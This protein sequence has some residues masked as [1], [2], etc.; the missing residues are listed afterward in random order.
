MS[1][2]TNRPF[3]IEILLEIKTYDVDF[4]GVVSNIVYV[5]WL[6]DL[7]NALLNRHFSLQRLLDSGVLPAVAQTRI[8]YK[9]PLRLA[10]RPKGRMWA[11]DVGEKYFLLE[12][13]FVLDSQVV[14]TA[15]QVAVFVGKDDWQPTNMPEELA[16]LYTQMSPQAKD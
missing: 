10:D 15:E 1:S 2:E 4:A 3:E 13:E 14:A 8:D 16:R 9:A 12:A 11:K 5:R 7:R 6:D